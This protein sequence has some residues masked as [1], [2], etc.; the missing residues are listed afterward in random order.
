MHPAASMGFRCHRFAMLNRSD[1]E[2]LVDDMVA[3]EPLISENRK[4][5]LR[6]LIYKLI[7]KLETNEVRQRIS[8]AASSLTMLSRSPFTSH[9]ATNSSTL[10]MFTR[11]NADAPPSHLSLFYCYRIA[12]FTCSRYCAP[13]SCHSR[14]VRSIRVA[15]SSSLARTTAHA[16]FGTPR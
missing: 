15:T 7:E 8:I 2:V 9:P 6:R 5:Q 13:T 1:V 3:R 14:T 16:K 4:P 10:R 12:T 11:A